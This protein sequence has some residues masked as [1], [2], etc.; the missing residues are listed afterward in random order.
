MVCWLTE[1]M[2]RRSVQTMPWMIT[3]HRCL[4]QLGHWRGWKLTLQ[5]ACPS[6]PTTAILCW[7]EQVGCTYFHS[8]RFALG[9]STLCP[10]LATITVRSSAYAW[11]LMN[12]RAKRQGH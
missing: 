9:A 2:D 10:G 12:L 5:D 8:L 6:G 11:C 3:D 4:L 7:A 1:A